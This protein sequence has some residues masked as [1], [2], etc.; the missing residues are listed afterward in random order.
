MEEPP[1]SFH[2]ITQFSI[3]RVEKGHTRSDNIT[4]LALDIE[5]KIPSGR[6]TL[7]LI[8]PFPSLGRAG[9]EVERLASLC[10]ED[11]ESIWVFPE[12]DDGR[13]ARIEIQGKP[14]RPTVVIR[15]DLI[16]GVPGW[17]KNQIAANRASD[18]GR[19]LP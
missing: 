13:W 12:R 10:A 2:A 1:Y 16:D 9:K 5:S 4:K 18:S 6:Y 15:C 17:G 14:T 7:T 19:P 3:A 11:I 8:K